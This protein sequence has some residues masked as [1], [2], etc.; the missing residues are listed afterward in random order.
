[1]QPIARKSYTLLQLK[2]DDYDISMSYYSAIYISSSHIIVLNIDSQSFFSC[3][4]TNKFKQ[5]K[6]HNYLQLC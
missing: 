2:H 1:M 5:T 3:L 6:S 4:Q